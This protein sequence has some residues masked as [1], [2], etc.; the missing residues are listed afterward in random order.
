MARTPVLPAVLNDKPSAL[1]PTLSSD[2]IHAN[3]NALHA[4]RSAF[5][6]SERSERLRQALQNNIRTYID[7]PILTGDKV[8]YKRL[9]ARRWRGPAIVLGKDGQQVLLKHGG[10]YIRVHPCRLRLVQE[11]ISPV[12]SP[13]VDPTRRTA[14]SEPEQSHPHA[15]LPTPP[16][17]DSESDNENEAFIGPPSPPLTPRPP[18]TPR[19]NVI[20]HRPVTR[21]RIRLALPP[22]PAVL[23]QPSSSTST[24][25]YPQTFSA[26]NL[27]QHT[28]QDPSN[29]DPS[30]LRK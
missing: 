10:Y 27:V 5:I 15:A 14:M 23:P 17:S 28:Q 19:P 6:E 3:L 18:H 29:S 8:Y 2:I 7:T 24:P 12:E 26:L 1:T 20:C 16:T 11:S 25:E 4:A 30:V 21:S 13:A 22:S 9:D